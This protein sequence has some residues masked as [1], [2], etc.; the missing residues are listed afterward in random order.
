MSLRK[1]IRKIL[2]EAVG[3]PDGIHDSSVKLLKELSVNLDNFENIGDEMY[4]LHLIFEESFNSRSNGVGKN[5]YYYRP[6]H[7]KF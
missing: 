5:G 4:K 1:Q 2:R 6:T 3:V 7:T